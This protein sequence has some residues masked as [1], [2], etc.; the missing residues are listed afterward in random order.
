VTAED[1]MIPVPGSRIF[2]YSWTFVIPEADWTNPPR[3]FPWVDVRVST[4]SQHNFDY[5]NDAYG[6]GAAG[7]AMQTPHRTLTGDDSEVSGDGFEV[8]SAYDRIP[9]EQNTTWGIRCWAEPTGSGALGSITGNVVTF[10]LT[11]QSGRRLVTFARST[12]R[13]PKDAH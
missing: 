1:D 8:S 10:W 2:A 7:L 12:N 4:L 3:V 6:P 5:D 9:G 11:D 13:P